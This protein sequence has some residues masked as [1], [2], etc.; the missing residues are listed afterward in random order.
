VS[1]EQE[2][3]AEALAIDRMHADQAEAFI[4]ERVGALAISGD[5]HGIARWKAISRRLD[6]LRGRDRQP[7]SDRDAA[8]G[9]PN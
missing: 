1:P 8:A 9:P 6:Q 7:G 3:W 2:R 5:S 4:A